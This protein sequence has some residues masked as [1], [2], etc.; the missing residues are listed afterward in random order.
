MTP[1]AVRR[2][3]VAGKLPGFKI[4]NKWR[5]DIEDFELPC[6]QHGNGFYT[7]K[8]PLAIFPPDR[9]RQQSSESSRILING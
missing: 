7:Q 3:L 4:G 8:F 5:T 9:A 6:K 1:D 2:W